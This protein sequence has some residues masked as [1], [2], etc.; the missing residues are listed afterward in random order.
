[1][2]ANWHLGAVLSAIC[3]SS[4]TDKYYT[5]VSTEKQD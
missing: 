5:G 2:V 4:W 3:L 1:M